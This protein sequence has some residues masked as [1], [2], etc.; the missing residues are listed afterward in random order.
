MYSFSRNVNLIHK[1][2]SGLGN[3]LQDWTK[4]IFWAV[5]LKEIEL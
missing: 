5:L 1:G 3:N 2:F 4:V